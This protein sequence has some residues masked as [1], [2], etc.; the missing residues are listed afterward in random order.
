MSAILLSA[1]L[2][3]LGSLALG[4][5]V[6][7]ICGARV[8]SWLAAPVGMAVLILLA[9]P[10][11]H[12][13]G[14]AA[15]VSILTAVLVAGGL[16]LWA[17]RPQHRPPIAGLLAGL[18]VFLLVLVPFA[19]SG[20]GGTLGVSFDNDMGEHLLLAEA[21]RSGAVARITPLLS[22]YPLG[23]H[24][25]AALLSEG[26]GIR[27]DQAFA[28]IT[29]A[30]PVLMAWAALAT[31]RHA[32]WLAKVTVGTVVGL[33]FLVAAYYG[34]G[35]F[36]EL[37]EALFVVASALILAGYQQQLQWRRWIPFALVVAGAVSVYSL[38]G[39]AWPGVLLGTW[40]LGRAAIRTWIGGLRQAWAELRA[41]LVPGAIGVAV[42]VVVL[43]PQVPRIEKFVSRGASNNISKTN[44]GNLVGPL[45][46]WEAFGVWNNPDYQLPPLSAFS[47]GMWT[48]F[49]LALVIV[50]CAVLLRSRRWMLPLAAAASVVVWAY[51]AHSQSPYVAAKAL[52]IASP[53][54]LLVAALGLV[55]P[56]AIRPARWSLLP[57]LLAVALFVRVADSSWEAMRF[58]KVGP[59]NHLVELRTLRPLL[60]SKRTL[61]LGDDDFIQWE[62]AGARVTPAY[63]AGTAEVAL[64][65]EKA[66]T[67]G[68][69]LDFDTVAP[70]V[71]NEFDWVITTR[72]AAGSEP[73]PAMRL[74]RMTRSYALWRRMGTVQPR[75]IL[76]EG[77]NAAGI[78]DCATA[79]GRALVRGG[80]TAAIKP[81]AS[82]VAVP[83]IAPGRSATVSLPLAPGTWNLETP[84]LSPL[85][86]K[87]LAPGLQVTLPANLERP[88][89]RWPV[90]Q[91][92][93]LQEGPIAVTFHVERYWLTPQSDVATPTVLLATRAGPDQIVPIR[94][95]CGKPV[96]WYRR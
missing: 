96:D 11:I 85:P 37:L 39:V 57:P 43:I 45:P 34:Q 48:A 24:A 28:G 10:A 63:F 78:L 79:A 47:G 90:G 80:G 5:G 62:L 59:T 83:P 6:L 21:Y 36:K 33:P 38:Q 32:R 9:V 23:P 66:F 95:A 88:G 12:L 60:G 87:V 1:I 20:R 68:E 93:V 4:Q 64:R 7:A 77:P 50:G 72:D 94:A 26:L 84:Y 54:L 55:G 46:G 86:L 22:D 56:R 3:C 35:S 71:L 49:V 53:L 51:A 18:P 30:V 17:R 25:L 74:V 8:W 89:P 75:K 41:E 76:D 14:R 13:P 29:A 44:L 70:A 15:T 2:T 27:V 91:V 82:A 92:S 19:A 58:S 67:Y 61:Y 65:P 16:L 31:V 73:P 81:P 42:L 52:V 40:V 69:P